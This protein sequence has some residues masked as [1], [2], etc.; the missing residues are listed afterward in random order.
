MAA[1]ANAKTMPRQLLSRHDNMAMRHYRNEKDARRQSGT[2]ET[3]VCVPPPQGH[4]LMAD[5]LVNRRPCV[6]WIP[7]GKTHALRL[8]RGPFPPAPLDTRPPAQRAAKYQEKPRS[9]YP[10]TTRKG[11]K[12]DQNSCRTT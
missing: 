5:D 2:T 12:G 1:D 11:S 10:R 8:F 9:H 7:P 6:K 4:C 3:T